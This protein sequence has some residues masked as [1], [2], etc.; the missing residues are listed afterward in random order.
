M[1]IA[2]NPII[3][4]NSCWIF[5]NQTINMTV[6]D[7]TFVTISATVVSIIMTAVTIST[8]FAVTEDHEV[9]KVL[10]ARQV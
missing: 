9:F 7:M 5:M 6:V 10:L 4:G 3:G 2:P 8:A 1:H